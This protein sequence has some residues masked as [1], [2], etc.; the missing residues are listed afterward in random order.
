MGR[1]KL[2]GT[3]FCQNWAWRWV[4]G[5]DEEQWTGTTCARQAQPWLLRSQVVMQLALLTQGKR[6]EILPMTLTAH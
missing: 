4:A 6:N 5:E 2:Q 1:S 3:G